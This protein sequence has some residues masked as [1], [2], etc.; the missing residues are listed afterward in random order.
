MKE[1]LQ[2]QKIIDFAPDKG[3][4]GGGFWGEIRQVLGVP[5][6]S[7]SQTIS[8]QITDAL[9]GGSG[10]TSVDRPPN[11]LQDSVISALVGDPPQPKKIEGPQ[12]PY[13]SNHSS[14]P[15]PE[16]PKKPGVLG[17]YLKSLI[18]GAR[19]VLTGHASLQGDQDG[20]SIG[21]EI[22]S[23]LVPTEA[24]PKKPKVET[25]KHP[26]VTVFVP[27]EEVIVTPSPEKKKPLAL[28]PGKKQ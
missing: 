11:K 25:T 24:K 13:A 22:W 12:Y 20:R 27:P 10:N 18:E 17:S 16:K 26:K 3:G 15:E 19:V 9:G 4:S 21:E 28:P 8:S 7:V 1:I 6:A 14:I 23:A 2:G 5:D